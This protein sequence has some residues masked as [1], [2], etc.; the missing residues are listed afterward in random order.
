MRNWIPVCL[1]LVVAGV[2]LQPAASEAQ[3]APVPPFKQVADDFA[4]GLNDANGTLVQA[5]CTP[6]L[7]SR[8]A[9]SFGATPAPT[10]GAFGAFTVLGGTQVSS[11]STYAIGHVVCTHPDGVVDVVTITLQKINGSWKVAGGPTSVTKGNPL[12]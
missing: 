8:L 1:L 7:W 11:G 10:Q 4:K 2:C 9:P 3:S 5:N 12:Q 6:A